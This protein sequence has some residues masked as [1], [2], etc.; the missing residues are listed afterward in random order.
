[1]VCHI[2]RELGYGI[3]YIYIYNWIPR[4]LCQK[5]CGNI[6]GNKHI[7]TAQRVPS[8]DG[9]SRYTQDELYV[10]PSTLIYEIFNNIRY[11]PINTIGSY[12]V[13]GAKVK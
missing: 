1:M 7:R 5:D 3:I 12:A 9:D 10:I 13:M 11:T 6:V 8:G 2:G 4:P